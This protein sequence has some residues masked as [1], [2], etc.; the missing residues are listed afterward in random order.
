MLEF[1][2]GY[3]VFSVFFKLALVLTGLY[4]II[5]YVVPAVF[6]QKRNSE[7]HNLDALIRQKKLELG[8]LVHEEN[9]AKGGGEASSKLSEFLKYIIHNYPSTIEDYKTFEAK[10]GWQQ[11]FLEIEFKKKFQ[12]IPWITIQFIDVKNVIMRYPLGQLHRGDLNKVLL[13]TWFERFF[14]NLVFD[15]PMPDM[16]KLKRFSESGACWRWAILY[17][18][19]ENKSWQ[20][21]FFDNVTVFQNS[22]EKIFTARS[23]KPF[24]ENYVLWWEK[25]SNIVYE[26]QKFEVIT[27]NEIEKFKRDTSEKNDRL[28]YLKRYHPDSF[29]WSLIDNDYRSEYEQLLSKNFIMVKEHLS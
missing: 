27:N 17:L 4:V 19:V 22:K 11:D 3:S 14:N 1:F 10:S 6:H 20:Q 28:K 29:Q 26:V 5:K 21:Y 18:T 13:L 16:E 2:T 25:L 7:V 12:E 9:D 24:L 15:R 23:L 8:Q